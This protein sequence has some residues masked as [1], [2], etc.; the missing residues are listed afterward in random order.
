MHLTSPK[1]R[2]YLLRGFK[3]F[4]HGSTRCSRKEKSDAKK[5]P[6]ELGDWSWRIVKEEVRAHKTG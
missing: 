2:E 6:D 4:Y 3:S 5:I 1:G